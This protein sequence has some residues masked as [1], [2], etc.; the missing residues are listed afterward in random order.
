MFSQSAH[1]TTADGQPTPP[2]VPPAPKE[3]R[4]GRRRIGVAVATAAVFLAAMAVGLTA[5]LLGW[6]G[7]AMATMLPVAALV[8]IGVVGV[9]ALRRRIDWGA[10]RTADGA[11]RRRDVARAA[12]RS[13]GWV[14]IAA[15]SWLSLPRSMISERDLLVGAA[16]IVA[17]ATCT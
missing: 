9:A 14:L 17:S 3:R 15:A 5:Y 16:V 12:T 7:L 11:T 4:S 10:W 1:R 2:P 6:I 8:A 13:L